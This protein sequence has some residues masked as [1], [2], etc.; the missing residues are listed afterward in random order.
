M[1]NEREREREREREK[2]G[3]DKLRRLELLSIFI[4]IDKNEIRVD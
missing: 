1:K 3:R 4:S 2:G